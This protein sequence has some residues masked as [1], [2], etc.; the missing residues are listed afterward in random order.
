MIDAF[1]ARDSSS[2]AGHNN[3]IKKQK[4]QESQFERAMIQE[5]QN[6]LQE[7]KQRLDTSIK[8]KTLRQ[9]LGIIYSR[10]R[11]K[12][13]F[14]VV[15]NYPMISDKIHPNQKIPAH[16]TQD[17]KNATLSKQEKLE[18]ALNDKVRSAKKSRSK[19]IGNKSDY[20][21][22]DDQVEPEVREYPTRFK[23]QFFRIVKALMDN[24]P[25]LTQA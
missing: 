22:V 21:D 11:E 15:K 16:L 25:N 3:M 6:Y 18:K 14:F 4:Q 7:T 23:R 2:L 13:F 24:K 19:S 5:A 20:E 1:N 9:S 10:L 17:Q 8:R 12:F